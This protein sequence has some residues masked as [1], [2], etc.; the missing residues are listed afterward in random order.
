MPVKRQLN[1]KA[2]LGRNYDGES[3]TENDI[4]PSTAD[5]IRS[6]EYEE[7][8]T[9]QSRMD[10]IFLDGK[11]NYDFSAKPATENVVLLQ[12]GRHGEYRLIYDHITGQVDVL[13]L[14]CRE[15][16]YWIPPSPKRTE[17]IYDDYTSWKCDAIGQD[18]SCTTKINS[19]SLPERIAQL[20]FGPSGD[21]KLQNKSGKTIWSISDKYLN[22]QTRVKGSSQ[23]VL[24][25]TPDPYA[26]L[27]LTENGM[28]MLYTSASEYTK[29]FIGYD[30]PY[31]NTTQHAIW[32]SEKNPW[33]K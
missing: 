15:V 14:K 29:H 11:L 22:P 28:V 26:K 19:T 25:W 32:G 30:S 1:C 20:K 24:P 7:W 31:D 8:L 12:G 17:C 27:V 6:H 18:P 21:V 5:F 10:T 16:S 3:A 2:L 23:E 13:K 9:N 4:H 33:N